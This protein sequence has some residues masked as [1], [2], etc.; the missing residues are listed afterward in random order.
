MGN[1]IV[2]TKYQQGATVEWRWGQGKG[3]GKVKSSFEA[4]VSRKI[5]GSEIT[6]HGSKENP[7]Y[8]IETDDGENVLKLHSEL[9]K[10]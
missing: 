2:T 1:W 4:T 10:Q 3:A 8:Y 5:A 9:E 6:R 7:A